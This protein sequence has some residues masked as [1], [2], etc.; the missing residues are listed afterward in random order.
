MDL[1]IVLTVLAACMGAVGFG[2]VLRKLAAG[3]RTAE[4][5]AEW[6]EDLS[7]ERYRPML[8]LLSE[9]DLRFLSTQ[10]GFTPKMAREF[11][12]QR[13]QIFRGYLRWLQSDFHRVCSALRTLMLES[14]H[15]R[16]DLTGILLRQRALFAVGLV[17]IHIR[18]LFY[19]WG[20]AGV[21]VDRVM[22]AFDCLR[23]ELRQLVP[24]AVGLEA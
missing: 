8:R 11:R 5:T 1:L 14:Q 4:V 18:L 13:C 12:A 22:G 19:R 15:D 16:P 9:E 17:S 7:I 21:E 10:P 2:M 20:L 23:L 6:I 24:A 3:P